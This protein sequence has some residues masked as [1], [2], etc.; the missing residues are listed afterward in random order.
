ME[1]N[2]SVK[3]LIKCC[4]KSVDGC[5]LVN[6]RFI[7]KAHLYLLFHFLI[8]FS[9]KIWHPKRLFCSVVH[10]IISLFAGAFQNCL[11]YIPQCREFPRG[12][13]YIT[14][15]W[16]LQW[17]RET[18]LLNGN[19]SQIRFF[20][21]KYFIEINFNF[22]F[23]NRAPQFR[24]ISNYRFGTNTYVFIASSVITQIDY[25]GWI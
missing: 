12:A 25:N 22:L 5:N 20:V 9:W 6:G 10:R 18:Y 14:G 2:L 11:N 7:I 8:S 17:W 24:P 4:F 3:M 1:G 19:L 13:N 23:R 16:T 21:S 15:A